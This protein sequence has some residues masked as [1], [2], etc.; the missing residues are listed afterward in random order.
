VVLPTPRWHRPRQVRPHQP[1]SPATA[2]KASTRDLNGSGH[3]PLI[4]R[5][6][7]YPQSR[8]TR[9]VASDAALEATD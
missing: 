4:T 8:S 7:I 1:P 3:C 5:P 6:L 9:A 2:R